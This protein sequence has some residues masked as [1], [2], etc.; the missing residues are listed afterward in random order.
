MLIVGV[1]ACA[2]TSGGAPAGTV[3]PEVAESPPPAAIVVSAPPPPPPPPPPDGATIFAVGDII[4]HS[5]VVASAANYAAIDA[6]GASTNHDGWDALLAEIAPLASAADF[7]IVNLETPVAPGKNGQTAAKRFNA[8]VA[9]LDA[10]AGA[11]FDAVSMANNHVWDQGRDGLIETLEHVGTAGLVAAGAGPTCAGAQAPVL[12]TLGGIRVAWFSTTRV[13]NVHYNREPDT[14]CVNE[15]GLDR[16]VGQVTQAKQDG[17][18][19][20]LMSVHWGVE[21]THTPHR[22]DRSLGR[23]LLEAGV[24]VIIGHHPHM[25]QP[26]EAFTAADGRATWVA[27]SLGNFLV[28]QGWEGSGTRYNSIE[29]RDIGLMRIELARD[30]SGRAIVKEMVVE[31]GFIERGAELCLHPPGSRSR[32]RPARLSDLRLAAQAA[33]AAGCDAIYA[34]RE[35]VIAGRL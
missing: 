24:D 8:P 14:A 25:L 13:A 15:F 3:L 33:G 21:Y 31:A 34:E 17:A 32:V 26:F 23:S 30:D 27:W 2:A 7:A 18:E 35:R 10:L 5:S 9:M 11:G 19:I 6:S 20:V 1:F 22:W 16:L 29:T 28:G 4:P 12:R